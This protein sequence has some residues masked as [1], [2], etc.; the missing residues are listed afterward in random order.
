MTSSASTDLGGQ[1]HRK[2]FMIFFELIL[3]HWNQKINDCDRGPVERGKSCCW[4]RRRAVQFR[5]ELLILPLVFFFY[6][7]LQ[8]VVTR[9]SS[10]IEALE[11]AAEL[12]VRLQ[13]WEAEESEK[14]LIEFLNRNRTLQKGFMVSFWASFWTAKIVKGCLQTGFLCRFWSEVAASLGPFGQQIWTVLFGYLCRDR[15]WF[16]KFK[17][18]GFG[19]T[20]LLDIKQ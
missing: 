2:V 7:L 8:R 10:A 20:T 5:Y 16:C 19:T 15:D 14:W 9:R 18:S 4:A 12:D 3:N 6:F 11:L 1:Q 17:K 13:Q